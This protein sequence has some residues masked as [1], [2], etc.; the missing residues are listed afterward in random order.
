MSNSANTQV[1]A[2]GKTNS[3]RSK[4]TQEV[5]MDKNNGAKSTAI[6]VQE[7]LSETSGQGISLI[8]PSIPL[9]GNRPIA[10]STLKISDQVSIAGLRPVNSSEFQVVGTISAMGERPIAASNVKVQDTIAVSG[11]RPIAVS[12]LKISETEMIMGNR[13]ISSNFI[14]DEDLMGYLD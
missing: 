11:I 14:D 13:P 10:A 5:N 12:T 8:E 2:N 6:A 1:K 7:K 9:P 4:K 3:R